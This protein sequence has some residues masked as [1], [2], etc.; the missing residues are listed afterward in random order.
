MPKLKDKAAEDKKKIRQLERD[1][2]K[3][4]KDFDKTFSVMEDKP[5]RNRLGSAISAVI[6]AAILI[7]AGLLLFRQDGFTAAAEVYK[8]AILYFVA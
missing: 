8:T 4:Q 5:K 1:I 7:I 3:M 2:K 6:A